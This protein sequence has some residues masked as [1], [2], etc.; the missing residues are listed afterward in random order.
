MIDV[1]SLEDAVRII[2][3]PNNRFD[4]DLNAIRMVILNLLDCIELLQKRVNSF[5]KQK[6]GT[7]K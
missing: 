1:K 3:N 5:E 7:P 6:K 2:Q 4:A